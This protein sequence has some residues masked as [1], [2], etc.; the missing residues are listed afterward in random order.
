MFHVFQSTHPRRVWLTRPTTNIRTS[1][2]NPHTHEGCDSKSSISCLIFWVSIHTPTKGVTTNQTNR[3]IAE[4]FQSTHPRRV[5]PRTETS[6]R[7]LLLFQSTHP[8]RVWHDPATYGVAYCWFQSTHPR[9]VWL[10]EVLLVSPG[11]HVSIHTPTKGVTQ[12][13][14]RDIEQCKFQST[15]PRR[16]WH[17]IISRK[18]VEVVFQSTHPRRVWLL[19]CSNQSSWGGVSI[20]TP[21]KGVTFDAE[22]FGW[23]KG[24]SIHTPTKGVTIYL[25][26]NSFSIIVSIHTPTKGVTNAICVIILCVGF[27]STHPRRVWRLFFKPCKPIMLVSI[28][29]PT[30]GVTS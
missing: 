10:Y 16:V 24:V 15:H 13:Y 26:I 11:W 20:H 29:T 6:F 27:Q 17:D 21:T 3:D 5:W 2:F 1:S 30:K 7:S 4:Q 28:H 25:Y 23:L 14:P 18:I 19:C 8:R 12:R 9:R 22:F